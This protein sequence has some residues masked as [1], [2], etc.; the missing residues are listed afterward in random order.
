MA[1]TPRLLILGLDGVP[2]SLLASWVRA[3]HLPN[4]AAF[5][6]GA[7][8]APL[9]CTFP[10]HTATGWPSLFNGRLP[11]EHGLF[12]FWDC[13]DPDYRLRPVSREEAG[14]P[15]LWD[16]LAGQ[17]WTLGLLNLPMSHPPGP[18]PGYQITWPLLPTL[19]Y[20]KPPELARELARV[21]GHIRPDIACMYDGRP[22]YPDRALSYIDGRTRT[23]LHLLRQR[24][25]DAVALVFTELDRVLHHFWHAADPRHPQ[26]SKADPADRTVIQRA[27]A[28]VDAAVGEI[29]AEIPDDCTVLVVSD[30]GF[31]PG[32][33][34]VR[35][36][37]LLAE[38][39]FCQ[40][41][42]LAGEEPERGERPDRDLEIHSTLPDLVW[43]R[44]RAYMAAPSSFGVNLNLEGRQCRG[45][46]RREERE[47][48]LAGL[49][50]FLASL[51]DPAGGPLFAAVL[52]ADEAYAGPFRDRAP[53]LLLVP[54]DPALMVLCDIAGPAWSDP[55]QTGLHRLEGIWMLRAPGVAPGPRSEAM[56]VETVAGHLLS[57]LGI[58]GEI[59]ARPE[60]GLAERGLRAA[61][62]PLD[63]WA[64]DA[65]C[66]LEWFDEP[67][68]GGAA[69]QPEPA[70]VTLE[71]IRERMRTMGYL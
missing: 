21:G 12:Q 47:G 40:M 52:R 53:D 61:G 31:G 50:E 59:P 11:G 34:G 39:G 16:V 28:A 10:P 68:A 20:I 48:V 55:G 54:S 15:S 46:V 41:P 17:G 2:H 29:L 62:L 14:V 9:R 45:V 18:W 5:A 60:P 32:T 25:V 43:E 33:R 65:S 7:A 69:L 23:L 51:E 58:A 13:Q 4:L 49:S 63:A 26:H 70:E 37:S 67:I 57:V 38:G 8:T 71:E 24:P 42:S 64:D 27:F 66:L 56:A 30:H 36:H 19:H 22:G 3:G 6:A 1:R 35:L 44:T